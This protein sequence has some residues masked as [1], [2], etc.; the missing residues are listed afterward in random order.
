MS[1]NYGLYIC[2][3]DGFTP[4][5]VGGS[6]LSTDQVH[7]V[8]TDEFVI[9]NNSYASAINFTFQVAMYDNC[10]LTTITP[11]EYSQIN[12]WLNRKE[13]YKLKIDVNYYENIYWIGRFNC[14]PIILNG[15]IYGIELNFVSKYPYGFEDTVEQKFS[16]K[17]FI[18]YNNTDETGTTY[19]TS[20]I[21]INESGDLTVENDMDS[22]IMEIKNCIAGEVITIDSI[23]KTIETTESSH[24]I[25]N[26][27][28]WNYPKL[29]NTYDNKYN[30]FTT[31]LDVD[32]TIQYNPVRKAGLV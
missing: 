2:N 1:E 31:S 17:S 8:G 9:V 12:R 22:E 27:F 20:I 5:A 13:D 19:M 18:V 11:D 21:T 16:G 23:H 7:I 32:Y 10:D 30:A 6:E 3:F 25:Y 29:C 26:D 15:K 28:N 14:T 4:E 24:K